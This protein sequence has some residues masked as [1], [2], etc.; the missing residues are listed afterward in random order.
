MKWVLILVVSRSLIP[1]RP[2]ECSICIVCSRDL[3]S[4][5]LTSECKSGLGT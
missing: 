5:D 2:E 4:R 3:H 1:M